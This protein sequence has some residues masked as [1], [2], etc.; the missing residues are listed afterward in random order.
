[1]DLT[2]QEKIEIFKNIF[3]GRVCDKFQK[4]SN[5]PDSNHI[6]PITDTIIAKIIKIFYINIVTKPT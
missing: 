3:R 2:S 1:M 4:T 5:M 6:T